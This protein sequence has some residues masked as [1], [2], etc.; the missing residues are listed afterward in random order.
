MNRA[1]E[2]VRLFNE[3]A[4]R[5]HRE[6]GLDH[7]VSFV[8][9]VERAAHSNP[10][11]RRNVA[12]LRDYSELRNAIVH[13]RSYPGEYVAE[14]T[15]KTMARF[16]ALVEAVGHRNRLIPAHAKEVRVF[17]ED[18]KLVDALRSMDEKDISQ[19]VLLKGQEHV[20]LTAEGV[21][22]WLQSRVKEGIVELAA[23]TVG[24]V[25]RY[26]KGEKSAVMGRNQTVEEALELFS[27]TAMNRRSARIYA[28]IITHSGRRTEKPL[29]IVTAWD[30][31]KEAGDAL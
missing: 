12:L 20:I 16:R 2:F 14:P 6:S 8:E 27:R 31:L 25:H 30:L 28:I 13:Y 5:L 10:V 24:E 17:R 18:E 26:E 22:E 19:V 15:E 29:G 4:D 7:H 23:F 1:D 9:L 11:V 3:L 21:A